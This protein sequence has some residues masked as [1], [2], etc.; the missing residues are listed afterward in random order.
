MSNLKSY[1][2]NT[3]FAVAFYR[4][5]D[6]AYDGDPTSEIFWQSLWVS[7]TEGRMAEG[8]DNAVERQS[9]LTTHYKQTTKV[10]S[11]VAFTLLSSELCTLAILKKNA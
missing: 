7:V 9:S 10:N 8:V 11:F 5:P 6:P 2:N 3:S 1:K 4:P